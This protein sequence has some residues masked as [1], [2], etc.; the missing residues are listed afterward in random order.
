MPGRLN[1]AWS[2]ARTKKK[3]NRKKHHVFLI[4]SQLLAKLILAKVAD[5]WGSFFK[6][7]QGKKISSTLQFTEPY[8]SARDHK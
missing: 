5:G 4:Y 7:F 1:I 2:R 8:K 6:P 3:K